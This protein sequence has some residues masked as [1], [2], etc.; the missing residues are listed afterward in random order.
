MYKEGGGIYSPMLYFG[1]YT[2]NKCASPDLGKNGV[3]FFPR[4]GGPP[5]LATRE[6]MALWQ[7][8]IREFFGLKRIKN[9]K[10]NNNNNKETKSLVFR[11]IFNAVQSVPVTYKCLLKN[12]KHPL[13][14][15]E[16]NKIK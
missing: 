11:V 6:N 1:E 12:L 15:M 5:F 3:N 16:E 4:Y 7:S 9:E 2:V 14:L 13:G 8:Y 10:N